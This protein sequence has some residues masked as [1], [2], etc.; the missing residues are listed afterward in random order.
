MT[1]KQDFQ[2]L[3]ERMPS[4]ASAIAQLLEQKEK[5]WGYFQIEKAEDKIYQLSIPS[6]PILKLKISS[7][8]TYRAFWGDNNK[9]SVY[10]RHKQEQKTR[11]L[12]K[13]NNKSLHSDRQPLIIKNSA[14]SSKSSRQTP[15]SIAVRQDIY[16]VIFYKNSSSPEIDLINKMIAGFLREKLEKIT[17]EFSLAPGEIM[18]LV[19][20][21]EKI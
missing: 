1:S 14:I 13:T 12:S 2:N 21:T 10:T 5:K 16:E 17:S 18:P 7:N 15:S 19:L 4:L 6:L 3:V 20:M 8:H 11:T 9:S